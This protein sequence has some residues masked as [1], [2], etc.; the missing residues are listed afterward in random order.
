MIIL[1]LGIYERDIFLWGEKP[2]DPGSLS[3]R[4]RRSGNK[5][6]GPSGP[7]LPAFLP[8]NAGVKGISAA[9]GEAGIDLAISKKS[10]QEM[11]AWLPTIQG[12]PLASSSLIAEPSA[13][14]TE[15]TLAPW[16]I[17]AI[18]LRPAQ[19]VYIL[20]ACVGRQPLA[21]GVIVGKDLSFFATAMRLAGALV[22]RQQFLPGIAKINGHYEAAWTPVLNGPDDDRLAK[23]T[24]AMPHVCRALT[25]ADAWNEAP[26]QSPEG[27]A[28]SILTPFI[29]E[30]VDSLVRSANTN[31]EISLLKARV[32]ATIKLPQDSSVHDRWLYSLRGAAGAL[33]AE[34]EGLIALA[35]Q[36]QEWQRPIAISAAAP[37]RLCFRLEEPQEEGTKPQGPLRG[38]KG[39]SF[40]SGPNPWF[41]RYLLQARDDPSLLI[42]VKDIWKEGRQGAA[43][44]AA[45]VFRSKSFNGQEYLLLALG[46]AAGIGP[47]IESSLKKPAPDGFELDATGVYTFLRE[48]APGL[49]QAGFGVMLPAWWTGKGTKLR[50]TARAQVKS[51]KM[52]EGGSISLNEIVQFDWQV[53]L[54]GEN[55]SFNELQA[56]ARLKAPL[57]KI[58]GQ[59]VEMSTEEIHA[60][61]ELWKA[62]GQR[63]APLR[64]IVQMALG[65]LKAP[66]NIDF[67][68]VSAT[69]WVGDL[70]A[71]I[72]GGAAAKELPPPLEF[73]GSLR[74]YQIR[75][76]SWLAFL[77]R[78]GLGACL[79]DDMGLGKTIQALALIQ[80]DWGSTK[81]PVL[82]ICPTS[83]VNNWR[84]EASRFTPGLPVLI[85]HGLTRSQ[86]LSFKEK[87]LDQAM[88]ISSY[89]L[90]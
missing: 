10:T 61:L 79:A 75:G 12:N 8:Y 87:A 21:P 55:L 65:G 25:P 80:R 31:G 17:T 66:G 63:Q 33:P 35:D 48:T 2:S 19:A 71:Q 60:A 64:E 3:P 46:Q 78:W 77:R 28:A 73:Q 22:A 54:G 59:W 90:V 42:L 47:Q 84:K 4:Q 67:Q 51:P 16:R 69:G 56:L 24:K 29:G 52:Q 11:V 81:R 58:R 86:G 70:M 38:Q 85:H 27:S 1:H 7:N 6:V 57:V 30:M 49:E 14:A 40:P 39:G 20:C 44:G 72:Q 83:V 18:C 89:A 50:L 68:G 23:I 82:L 36:I 74:P 37:F 62:K 41:V 15:V 5:R 32:S 43:K 26:S 34:E 76:Y 13:S 9:L 45:T 88:V 53:S